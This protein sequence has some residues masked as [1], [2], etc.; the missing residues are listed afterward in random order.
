MRKFKAITEYE[1][2]EAAYFW[3]LNLWSAE[4][5]KSEDAERILSRK[6][7][8]YELRANEYKVIV[9]ELHDALLDAEKLKK[10]K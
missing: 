10:I 2:L 8:L 9:D 6:S 7:E 1:T 3:Y 5:E 4:V